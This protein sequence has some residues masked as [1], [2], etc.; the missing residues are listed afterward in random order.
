MRFYLK[1]KLVS[2]GDDY[3]ILN[4]NQQVAYIADGYG[5]SL[6]KRFSFQTEHK[7]EIFDVKQQLFAFR[8]TFFIHPCP[9][10]N[11]KTVKPVRP[12]TKDKKI[13]LGIS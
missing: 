10:L 5:F 8:K 6:G 7:E 1:E 13:F 4:E 9:G 3:V 2:V 12:E 11:C